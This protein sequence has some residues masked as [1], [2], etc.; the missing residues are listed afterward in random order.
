MAFYDKA[1]VRLSGGE[2][3]TDQDGATINYGYESKVDSVDDQA[4]AGYFNEARP[5]LKFGSLIQLI[6]SGPGD[7]KTKVV[8]VVTNE[9]HVSLPTNVQVAD[10]HTPVPDPFFQTIAEGPLTFTTGG[11]QSDVVPYALSE[12]GMFGNFS[13]NSPI[14]DI[15]PPIAHSG[16]EHVECQAGQIEIFWSRIVTIGQTVNMWFQLR[17]AS[18]S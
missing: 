17:S 5:N 4:V 16:I 9:P 13:L 18:P 15:G 11:T 8:Y 7:R 3:S 12:V 14:N 2:C 1:F 10:L 6:Y